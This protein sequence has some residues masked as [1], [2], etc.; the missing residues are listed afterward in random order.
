MQNRPTQVRHRALE[1]R[2]LRRV[3]LRL[4]P[5]MM[6]CYFFALLDRVNVGFASLQ[7]NK[8]IGLS[9][10]VFGFGASL[11]FVFILPA[12]GAE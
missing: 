11:Y 3:T 7:M 10:A 8:D 5:F 4:M 2:T 1:K 6:A 12:R 9:P